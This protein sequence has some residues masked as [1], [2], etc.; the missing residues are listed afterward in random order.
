MQALRSDCRQIVRSSSNLKPGRD[1]IVAHGLPRIDRSA[2]TPS[3]L[4]QIV[5]DDQE[6]PALLECHVGNGGQ[7][8][9]CGWCKDKWGISWQIALR[10]AGGQRAE[11]KR[12]FDAMMDMRKVDVAVIE[13]ARRG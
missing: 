8:S 12:A 2:A 1:C 7:E 10:G 9:A 5:T 11:A 13:A 3:L 4:V 6:E